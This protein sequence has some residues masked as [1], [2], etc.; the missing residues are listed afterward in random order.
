MFLRVP[1]RH[2]ICAHNSLLPLLNYILKIVLALQ[3]AYVLCKI[4]EKSGP[5]PRNG[6]QHGAPFREEEWDDYDKDDVINS[7]MITFDNPSSSRPADHQNLPMVQSSVDFNN[8]SDSLGRSF[9]EHSE[10]IVAAED[11]SSSLEGFNVEELLD[12]L[13]ENEDDALVP[14]VNDVE[15]SMLS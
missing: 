7:P 11:D 4:F 3:D 1:G 2:I 15:V 5:G 13:S 14:N 6:E 8:E 9:P 12:L 10:A